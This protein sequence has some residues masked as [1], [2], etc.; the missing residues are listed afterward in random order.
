[1]AVSNATSN[2]NAARRRWFFGA[3]V[4]AMTV[5]AAS[6]LVGVNWLGH[7]KNSRWDVTGGISGHRI[8][9]RT[10]RILDQPGGA[11]DL[12][13]TT[14]Y[15]SDS[16]ETA[17]K[18]FFPRVGDLCEEIRQYRKSVE[19]RHLITGDE[20]AELRDRV[21]QKF[22]TAAKEYDDVANLALNVWNELTELLGPQR[23]RLA[24]LLAGESWLGGFTTLANIA[25][26]LQRD[27][28]NIEET[29]REV[30]DLVRGQGIPRY[31]EASDKIKQANDELKKHLEQTRDWTREMNKLVELLGDPDAEFVKT[32]RAKME[33]LATQ[34]SAL[35]E[36]A[37]DPKDPAVPE[38]PKPLLRE[39]AKA[40]LGLSQWLTDE[41]GRIETFV[42]QYPAIGQ[43]PR[44]R[45]R[46]A[47]FVME[48]PVLLTSSAE[49]LGKNGREL[50]RILAQGDNVALDQL[51]N[52][53]R[54]LRTITTQVEQGLKRWSDNMLAI[55]D[56]GPKVDAQS[57]EF[58]A[59]VSSGD[60]LSKPLDRLNEVS[61]K[62]SELPELKLDEVADRLQ[63]EN[64]IVVE[65]GDKV[66]VVTFDEAWPMAD[67]MGGGMGGDEG[68]PPRVFDGDSA[69]SNAILAMQSDKPMA[70]VVL[71]TFEEQVPPQMRQFQRPMTGPMPVEALRELKRRLEAMH[72]EVE[73]WNLAEEGAKDKPPTAD[74]GIPLVYVFLPPPSAPPPMFGRQPQQK[75]FTPADAE[76]ARQVLSKKNARG[77]FLATWMQPTMF[78]PP[79]EYGWGP[80]LCDDWGIEV[81][82]PRRVIRG[83]VDRKHP[84]R[85]AIDVVQWWYMQL[86][87]FTEHPIGYPLRARR[88]LMKDVCP[89][90]KAEKLPEGVEIAEVLE[91]PAGTTDIWAEGD[92]RRIFMALQRG[93]QDGSFTR[94][95]QALAPPFSVILAAT[96]QI[97]ADE[98]DKQ[99]VDEQAKPEESASEA[100]A[101]QACSKVVVMG[102]GLSLRDDFLQQ[103]VV[104]FGGKG[105]RLVTDPPPTENMDLFVNA[106]CWLADKPGL[107]AAGP[108]EVPVVAAIEPGS[109]RSVW[110]VTTG[111]AF[112]ALVVG[113]VMMMIRRK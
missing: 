7:L 86:S 70:K 45:I 101:S 35:K 1:M 39:F 30:E 91:V 82:A 106:L 88:M 66:K 75:Q 94:S 2:V 99:E 12:R 43:H 23:Q 55:L 11:D 65:Q 69:I 100:D 16:P 25:T 20:Q 80:I 48:L 83:V 32:T 6:V 15:D 61:T 24:D 21:Q 79:P 52:V 111:W 27:L 56:E 93:T 9:Q 109:R 95:E 8:S 92:V 72:F 44:W 19:V 76:V 104:R 62:I 37:G 26:V 14:V 50:R 10:Q 63:Q 33:Q 112:A 58:L 110:L 42:S 31:S 57:K 67:R 105:A 54:Q 22:G 98:P 68:A 102:N 97:A 4:I 59:Q 49:D 84:G 53:V 107:I 18:E 64:I 78:G 113:G 81:D 34:L 73:D 47:I 85:Y 46:Q 87:S 90:T 17:R 51:Q 29:R 38:D 36:I 89:V 108:A 103:R 28:K 13:I 74:E 40:A 77:L 71:V 3:N 5:L 96:K 41:S 60:A